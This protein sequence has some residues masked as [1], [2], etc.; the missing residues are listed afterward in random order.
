MKDCSRGII[1]P[2][3]II[4]LIT[5]TNPISRKHVHVWVIQTTFGKI[6]SK[7]TYDSQYLNLSSSMARESRQFSCEGNALAGM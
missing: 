5:S 7:S 4:D 6:R 2:L 3:K 1:L